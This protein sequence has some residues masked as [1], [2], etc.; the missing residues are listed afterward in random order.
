MLEKE[1]KFYKLPGLCDYCIVGWASDSERKQ[2]ANGVNEKLRIFNHV[3]YVIELHMVILSFG[4]QFICSQL[5][6]SSKCE[7]SV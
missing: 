7:C 6:P 5:S 3:L 2:L 1:E 4:D